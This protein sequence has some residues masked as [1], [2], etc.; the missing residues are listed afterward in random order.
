MTLSTFEL[1]NIALR[2]AGAAGNTNNSY[3]RHPPFSLIS[4]I[5][6]LQYF[7]RFYLGE[8]QLYPNTSF[9]VFQEKI[10]KKTKN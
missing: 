9:Y 3:L 7:Y 6:V 5:R 2:P 8:D 1:L 4:E 10:A